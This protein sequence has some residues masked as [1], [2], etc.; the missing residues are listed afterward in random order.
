LHALDRGAKTTASALGI[1]LS[2]VHQV[3]P[4]T[5]YAG[6][7]HGVERAFRRLFVDYGD[8]PSCLAANLY[9]VQGRRVVR[10]VDARVHD[11]DA[12]N[13]QRA[14]QRDHLGW[15]R[16]L[17]RI[18]TAGEERKFRRIAEDMSV[19]VAGA[20]RNLKIHRGARLGAF[21]KRGRGDRSYE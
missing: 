14:M 16:R 18:A 19:A 7:A 5:A 12:L 8:T 2:G 15:Q 10:S 6:L 9:A 1:V 3:Q 11:H 21:G 13:M 17:R 4:D 20:L